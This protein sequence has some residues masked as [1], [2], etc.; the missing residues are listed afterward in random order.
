MST[1][2]IE[3]AVIADAGFAVSPFS[4]L[5]VTGSQI[6][7]LLTASQALSIQRVRHIDTVIDAEKKLLLPSFVDSHTHLLELGLRLGRMDVSEISLPVALVRVREAVEKSPKGAWITGGG[8]MKKN[9]GAFP[10]AGLLDAISTEHCIALASHDAHAVWANTPA[11]QLLDAGAFR[12]EELPTDERGNF[13][14]LAL[15][16]AAAKLMTLPTVSL[17]EQVAALRR[18]QAEFFRCGVTETVSIEN[19]SALEAYRALGDELKLCVGIAI[20]AEHLHSA[21]RFFT[22][23]S[24][25]NLSLS[26]VKVFLDGSLGAETCAM[27]EPFQTSSRGTHNTGIS[28]YQTQDLISLF[29]RIER[30]GLP[31]VAHAIGNKAVRQA[32][33][34]FETLRLVEYD[35]TD[36]SS[37]IKKIKRHRI[38]H[39]QMIDEADLKRF[40]SLGITASMQPIHIKEDIDSA[41]TLLSE[42]SERDLYRFN[43]L[44]T[45]GVPLVFGSDAPIETPDVFAGLFYAAERRDKSGMVWHGEEKLDLMAALKAYTLEPRLWSERTG[46]QLH[47]GNAA[48][49][50][51][52]S[53]NILQSPEKVRDTKVL[54]TMASGD[55][56]YRASE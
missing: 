46:G 49:I 23:Y 42:K 21:Q 34:A 33:D 4:A 14:G 45:L 6:E 22:E 54:L 1:L 48:D 31:I 12:A 8:W 25:S 5:L 9:F 37:S 53:E 32:L 50:V 16:R 15:E 52:L 47:A 44:S 7:S 51:M 18:A 10:T 55:I 41:R 40:S 29:K 39:A 35:D 2:L 17:A 38:E 28:L 13:T 11:L 26:A 43:S 24:H 19:A 36:K 30:E 27:L 56:V 20:N 3:N